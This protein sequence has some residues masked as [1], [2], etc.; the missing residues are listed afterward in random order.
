MGNTQVGLQPN[1]ILYFQHSPN[2]EPG[3][4]FSNMLEIYLQTPRIQYNIS[5]VILDSSSIP[6]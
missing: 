2:S 4:N 6:C 1:H 5:I 3:E